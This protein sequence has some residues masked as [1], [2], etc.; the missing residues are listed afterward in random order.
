MCAAFL[1]GRFHHFNGIAPLTCI[2]AFFGIF[3]MTD[4]I[5]VGEANITNPAEDIAGNVTIAAGCFTC[6]VRLHAAQPLFRFGLTVVG[7]HGGNQCGVI[8]MLPGTDTDFAFVLRACELLIMPVID[9]HRFLSVEHACTHGKRKP[10]II[11][12]AQVSRNGGFQRIGLYRLRYAR[13]D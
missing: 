6:Q 7:N 5:G 11:S 13:F 12:T 9:R 1:K 3:H 8:R 2:G 10:L 4:V